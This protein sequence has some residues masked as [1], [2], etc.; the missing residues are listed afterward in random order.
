MP[1]LIPLLCTRQT[2]LSWVARPNCTIICSS[3]D[4]RLDLGN[5]KKSCH[6]FPLAEVSH[7]CTTRF[8]DQAVLYV[9]HGCPKMI[10]KRPKSDN[11]S[12]FRIPAGYLIFRQTQEEHWSCKATVLFLRRSFQW[13]ICGACIKVHA[14]SIRIGLESELDSPKTID[15]VIAV[16]AFWFFFWLGLAHSKW[17]RT[18]LFCSR[19]VPYPLSS[20][21]CY[22][23]LH[24]LLKRAMPPLP[25]LGTRHPK[26]KPLRQDV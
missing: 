9:S 7:F 23:A 22:Q 8:D 10:P 6:I 5:C 25:T 24:T 11:P 17:L 21:H 3:Q 13:S 4:R 26:P 2:N 15:A 19:T 18:R 14:S 20:H 16:S 1:R 12:E